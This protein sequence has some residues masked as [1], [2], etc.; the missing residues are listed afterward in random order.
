MKRKLLLFLILLFP[1][2]I[3]ANT[4]SVHLFYNDGCPFCEKEIQFLNNLKK[5][6]DFNFIKYKL[7]NKPNNELVK[8][9]KK[10]FNDNHIYIPYTVIGDQTFTGFNDSTKDQITKAINH[11]LE[12]DY[13]DTVSLLKENKSIEKVEL[14][15][16][17]KNKIKLPI[18]GEVDPTNISLPLITIV[19]GL[20]DGFNPCAMWVLILLLSILINTKERK[21]MLIL[22]GTFLLTSALIYLFFMSAWL[23]VIISLATL[24][25]LKIIIAII[26]IIGGII[27]LKGF[28]NKRRGCKVS[29]RKDG[30]IKKIKQ[31][32]NENNFLIALI[33]V[34]SLAISVNLFELAC[35]AGLPLVFTQI[36]ALN[37][38]TMFQYGFYLLLYTIFFLLDDIILFILAVKTFEV[39]GI[40]NRYT[41]YAHLIGGLIMLIIGL[42]LILKPSLLLF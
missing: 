32:T 16:L 10:F 1:F 22:G 21:K 5:D 29:K 38:L 35:S 7:D 18:L 3:K 17:E 4:I 15:Q 19:L 33:G 9:V 41:K 2:Y 13:Q 12:N 23:K 8:K 30:F 24:S 37:N 28:F 42:L 31:F 39:V 20:V 26:A 14:K 11:Y 25:Y 27:N 34:I 40:T 36:L 6:N